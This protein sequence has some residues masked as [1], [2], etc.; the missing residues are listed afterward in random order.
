MQFDRIAEFV[1]TPQAVPDD[2]LDHVATL[3]IDT[4]GVAAG[5]AA[6][7]PGMIARDHAVAFMNAD[8]AANAAHLMFDGRTASLSGA[9]YA[10]ATQIDN[11]DAHDGY[12]PTKGHIGCAVVPALF[13]FSEAFPDLEGRAALEALAMSYE[14]AARAALALHATVSDYHTSGAWNALGVV[15]LG[16]RLRGL[17]PEALRQAFGIAEYHGPRSQMMREIANPTMLHDG[18]GMGA[19]TGVMAVLLAERGFEGA[20][21]ITV[22]AGEV[23]GFWADLGREW[24]VGSNYMK[25]Y[26]ICRWAHAALDALKLVRLEHGFAADDVAAITVRTFAE[27][28]CLFDGMPDT[29]SKAQYSLKFALAV[30]LVHGEVGADN[31]AGAGLKDRAVAEV[32]PRVEVVEDARHSERFPHGRWSDVTV[33]LRDGTVLSSGDVHARGGPEAP[34]T[35]GEIEDKFHRLA[36]CLPD[37]RRAA[38]WEMRERL[39]VPGARFSELAGLVREAIKP[40]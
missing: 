8:R 4:I 35:L 24:T 2:A 9:A 10:A 13:A 6:L 15:A 16:A 19:M 3:L 27:A 18:S 36:A 11:L 25:P 30:M 23:R 38:I 29:T 26:P 22:E 17:D 28:A 20:P 40:G 37:A 39:M 5:A 14:V 33:T 12:N 21:A 34:M 31:I 32:L 7:A 1:L